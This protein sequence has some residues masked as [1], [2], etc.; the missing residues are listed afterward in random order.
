MKKKILSA[1]LCFA[2]IVSMLL[3]NVAFASSEGNAPIEKS[4]EIL[5]QTDAS[6]NVT[7]KKAQV[8]ITGANSTD[9]I[10]DKTILTDIRNVNGD[11]TFTQQADGTI[12]WENAG[13]DIKYTGTLNAEL[14]FSMKV[15][16]YLNDQEINPEDLMGK[17]GKVKIIYSFENHMFTDVDVDGETYHTCIPF[18]A[19]TSFSLPM[20]CFSNVESLDGGLVV[21]EFGNQYYILGVATPG[22]NEALNLRIMGLDK[23]V[24]FPESFGF[25]ADVTNF[26][27]PSVIT[28][29][30]THVTDKLDFSK[31]KTPEDMNDKIEELVAATE[32]LV[33]GSDKLSDGTSLLSDGVT[34]FIREFQAGLNEITEGSAQLDNDLYNLEEK[35][36]SLQ[37]EADELLDI[38][39]SL[40]AQL[41]DFEIPDADSIF[42]PEL[43]EA[44]QSL[45][46][47]AALLIKLLEELKSQLEEIM[48]FAEEAQGYIDQITEIGNT[49]YAELSSIDLDKMVA[50]A[51]ELAR[52]QAIEAAKEEFAGLPIADEQIET[53]INNIMS[54]V[55]LSSVVNEAKEHIANVEA[56][57]S[58]IPEIEIPE[59]NVDLDPVIEVLKDMEIQFAVMEEAA[60]KQE[61]IVA[62]LDSANEFLNTV[63]ENSSVIR[64]KSNELISGL[65]FADDVIK[66][67]HSYINSLK[68]AVTEANTGS[69]ELLNGV[70]AVDEGAQQLAEGT[71]RYYKEGI[72]TAADFA[73]Q[74]TLQA[75][76]KRCRAVI[77]AAKEYTNITGIEDETRGSIRFIVQTESIGITE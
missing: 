45:K 48:A 2:V 56:L 66:N 44:E 57:L 47:D 21:E 65:N 33:D 76:L 7:A 32:Q 20:D 42:T 50:D 18:M 12:I 75:F 60:G 4:D 25:I 43:M 16:Y 30:T 1:S 51:M 5:I 59:F 38:M 55:D 3:A 24:R 34:R 23:Y 11:E 64:T 53:I 35:K 17:T 14:P 70:Y 74:A 9:P 58:D 27:M 22:E 63:K 68:D 77:L 41:N 36:N 31:I 72:L 10:K 37:S 15:T 49:V 73:K 40:L 67:A 62:L 26:Q 61:E 19:V 52:V 29:V 46:E 8:T 71:E 69:E 54:K 28:C 39:D 13:K 6:G